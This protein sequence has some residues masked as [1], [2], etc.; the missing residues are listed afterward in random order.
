[1]RQPFML[2]IITAQT[3]ANNK[4]S[5]KRRRQNS[6]NTAFFYLLQHIKLKKELNCIPKFY[7]KKTFQDKIKHTKCNNTSHKRNLLTSP[8]FFSRQKSNKSFLLTMVLL[9]SMSTTTVSPQAAKNYLFL[10]PA[11]NNKV[12]NLCRSTSTTM[13]VMTTQPPTMTL[14][15]SHQPRFSPSYRQILRNLEYVK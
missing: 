3:I 6:Q 14:Y 11:T 13:I 10:S 4:G 9:S 15:N 7:Y 8:T 2:K 1:M 12:Y 5:K